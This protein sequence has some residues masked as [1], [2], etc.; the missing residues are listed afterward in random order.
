MVV[1]SHDEEFKAETRHVVQVTENI[2]KAVK[3]AM[4]IEAFGYEFHSGEIGVSV[5]RMKLGRIHHK[6]S[7]M[8]FLGEPKPPLIVFAR[9]HGEDG[10]WKTEWFDEELKKKIEQKNTTCVA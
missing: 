8:W 4:N 3:T 5:Y 6:N 2:V 9:T 7:L 10:F 1:A